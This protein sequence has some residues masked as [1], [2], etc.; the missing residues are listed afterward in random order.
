M[1]VDSGSENAT[2]VVRVLDYPDPTDS[3]DKGAI[4]IKSDGLGAE[5]M[6]FGFCAC[7][8]V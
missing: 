7:F 4:C 6:L 8:H 2:L 5:P 3:G 1:C